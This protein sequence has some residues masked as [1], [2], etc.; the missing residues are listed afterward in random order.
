MDEDQIDQ[1]EWDLKMLNKMALMR[2]FN[3]YGGKSAMMTF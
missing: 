3:I 2:Q 1:F